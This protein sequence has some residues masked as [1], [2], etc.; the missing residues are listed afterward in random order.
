MEHLTSII[1]CCILLSYW[2]I[3]TVHQLFKILML[4]LSGLGSAQ[5]ERNPLSGHIATNKT[6]MCS[7][8]LLLLF[9]RA[10]GWICWT[11]CLQWLEQDGVWW[12]PRYGVYQWGCSPLS[13]S[14][15]PSGF[16]NLLI[17]RLEKG[18]ITFVTFSMLILTG[19][20]GMIASRTFCTEMEKLTFFI[21]ISLCR[22]SRTYL[23][24]YL[25][26]E[27]A[28]VLMYMKLLYV[29]MFSLIL[30]KYFKMLSFSLI[31]LF[32]SSYHDRIKEKIS[33]AVLQLS[34]WLYIYI[35]G[36]QSSKRWQIL[37]Y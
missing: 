32:Q 16:K 35:Y 9:K 28:L 5:W 2:R 20:I 10:T 37:T 25:V 11:I 21:L 3:L 17:A 12:D 29:K 27:Y 13:H 19:H 4:T 1:I 6:Y 18:F 23:L 33:L 24:Q 26:F 7:S 34:L 14:L 36:F 31:S 8:S 22:T 30:S 15:I